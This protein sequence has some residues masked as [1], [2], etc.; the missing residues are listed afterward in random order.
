GV[1]L[2]APTGKATVQLGDKV[3]ASAYTL[4]QFLRG[5]GRW[6]AEFGYRV[7]PGETKEGG[8]ATVVVDEASVLTEEMLAALGDSLTGVERL[9]LCGPPRQLPPIGAG[10]PFADLVSYL[11]NV[12]DGK[13]AT[14]PGSGGGLAE[15]TI[16]RRQR[17][18]GGENAGSSDALSV[19]SWFS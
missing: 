10:R 12:A 15:L 2:L 17:A 4:A 6:D 1:L 8:V 11:R 3:K 9:V 16:G 5:S 13:D 14:E 7:R 19:A 18:T